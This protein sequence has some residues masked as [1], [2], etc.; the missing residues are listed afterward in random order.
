[1]CTFTTEIFKTDKETNEFKQNVSLNMN[2]NRRPA[3]KNQSVELEKSTY[4]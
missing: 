2:K 3:D 4:S 1:M